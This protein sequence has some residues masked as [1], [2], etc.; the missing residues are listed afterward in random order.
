MNQNRTIKV[1]FVCMGNICRSPTADAVFRHLVK[2]A[3]VDHLIHVDSAGTHAY[4]I[5]NPPDHRAQNTA[6]QRGYKMHD[7][8]ARAVQPNDFEEF[9]YILAM[10]K[11]NLSLLQQR[12]PQQ[13]INKIQLFMQYSTQVNPDVE[14]PDPYFG[15]NQG[16]ELVLDMVEEA[17]QGL[18]AHLRNNK[19]ETF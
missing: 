5:G 11:E 13:H 16:F 3:G 18:L 8:R 19:K 17:S 12:S 4:H 2:E 7:L 1:L 10:D 15:G 9:D 6:L 14:V